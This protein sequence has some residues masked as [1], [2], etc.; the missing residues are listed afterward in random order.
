M[1]T[2]ASL[3]AAKGGKPLGT[4]GLSVFPLVQASEGAS[5]EAFASEVERAMQ[6]VHGGERQ[7][8]RLAELQGARRDARRASFGQ[9]RER[10]GE[11]EAHAMEAVF[12]REHAPVQAAPASEAA[13]P[14]GGD[15]QSPAEG[16]PS[17]PSSPHAE[18][19]PAAAL[20][21]A[22]PLPAATPPTQGAVPANVTVQRA[23]HELTAPASTPA[24]ASAPESLEPASL[25]RPGSRTGKPSTAPLPPAAPDPA[26]LERAAEILRQIQLH[27]TPHVRRLTLDLEPAEL[28]RLSVQ[29]AL[30]AGKVA[31]IVR[32]ENPETLALLEQRQPELLQ[33]LAQRGIPADSVRFELGFGGQRSRRGARAPAAA[34]PAQS[35]SAIPGSPSVPRETHAGLDLYA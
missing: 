4:E 23:A 32:G 35:T 30:R 1:E 2:P 27:A 6:R 21:P 13:L 25:V 12:R 19:R 18:T 5:G 24:P 15:S 26:V 17:T 14:D 16:A 10:S 34:P 11:S 3:A 29:L 28:G 33:V 31:A 8:R 22:L 20:D 7:E 9:E